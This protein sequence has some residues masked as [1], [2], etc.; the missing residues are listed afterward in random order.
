[1]NNTS[2]YLNFEQAYKVANNLIKNNERIGLYI[3]F[4]INTG[5]RYSDLKGLTDEDIKRAELNGNHLRIIEKKTKKKRE[6]FLNYYV[7]SAYKKFPQVGYLFRTQKGTA[8]TAQNLNQRLKKIFNE[9]EFLNVSTHSLRKTFS[10]KYYDKA[11]NKEEA[12]IY[13]CDLLNHSTIKMTKVYLG[14]RREELSNI[15][16]GFETYIDEFL[17]N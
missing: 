16:K 9:S 10:R 1:M 6:I 5:L 13:L 17:Y 11:D 8:P 14:I 4:Q 15:Y 3:M 7:L 2:D 12:L